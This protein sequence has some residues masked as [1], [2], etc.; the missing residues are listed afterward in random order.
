[1]RRTRL[2]LLLAFLL[3]FPSS[4]AIQ[5]QGGP[6]EDTLAKIRPLVVSGN[7]KHRDKD[8]NGAIADFT[9][10]I[11]LG[12]NLPDMLRAGPYLNR[13]LAYKEKG[14]LDAALADLNKAIKLQS[15]NV[16]A[17]QDRGEIYRKREE[18]EKAIADFDKALKISDK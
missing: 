10:A 4:I 11:E 1:M 13:G 8:Y 5:A 9:K 12:G 2:N 14:E 18:A 15:N 6:Y 17:Y 7:Q 16:Y 3:L